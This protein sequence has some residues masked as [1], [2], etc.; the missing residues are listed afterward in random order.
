MTEVS[1]LYQKLCSP[2]EGHL[3]AVYRIFRYL[4]NNLGKHPGRMEYD[5]MYEPTDENAFEV[6]GRDLDEWK[7]FY[8]NA[9]EMMTRHT[10][11]AL[12]NYVVIKAYV[13]ANH[14]GN[15]ANGRSNSGIIIY[16]NNAPVIWYSKQ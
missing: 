8:P 14:A 13:D 15:M 16:V 7:D 9:Q 1:C 4:Q 2:R 3:D 11:E 12:G 10:P 5:P 6:I